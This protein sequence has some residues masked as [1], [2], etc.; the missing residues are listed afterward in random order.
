MSATYTQLELLAAT[1]ATEAAFLDDLQ[2]R[3]IIRHEQT[4]DAVQ[5]AQTAKA[6][7]LCGGHLTRNV[8]DRC[9][10]EVLL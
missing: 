6:C 3:G 5:T 2:R 7:P 9:G 10:M 4:P 1:L 8:C